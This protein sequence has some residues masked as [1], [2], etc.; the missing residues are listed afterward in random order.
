MPSLAVLAWLIGF[1]SAHSILAKITVEFNFIQPM[2]SHMCMYIYVVRLPKE[3]ILL[4]TYAFVFGLAAGPLQE[5]HYHRRHVLLVHRIVPKD[6]AAGAEVHTTALGLLGRLAAG[7]HFRGR[8]G[9]HGEKIPG[10]TGI[11]NKISEIMAG[12]RKLL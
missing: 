11:I 3:E 1:P 12:Y 10:N 6:E 7:P 2:V 4:A 5:S 9:R 8:S